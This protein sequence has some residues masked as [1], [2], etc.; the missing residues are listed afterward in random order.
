MVRGWKS[1]K[2]KEG[3]PNETTLKRIKEGQRYL[4]RLGAAWKRSQMPSGLPAMEELRWTVRAGKQGR[5]RLNRVYNLLVIGEGSRE[6]LHVLSGC[7]DSE[8][9]RPWPHSQTTGRE[10]HSISNLPRD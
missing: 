6:E 3:A 7:Q 9:D 10:G 4:G 8:G 1:R 2:E 5:G